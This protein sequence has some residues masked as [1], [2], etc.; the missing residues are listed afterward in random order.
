[1]TAT[2]KRR[3]PTKADLASGRV[4][5]KFRNLNRSQRNVI[6]AKYKGGKVTLDQLAAEYRV[7][8]YLIWQVVNVRE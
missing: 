8:T 3:P 5:P 2:G 7:S 1:M 4:V 6:R